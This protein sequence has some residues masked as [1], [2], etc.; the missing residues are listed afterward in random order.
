MA[1]QPLN[2]LAFDLGAES[3]RAILGTLDGQRLLLRELH[4][5]ANEPVT[6]PD[7]LHWD[8]LRLWAELER[9]LGLAARADGGELASVGLDTW[10]VDYALLDSRGSLIG[11]PYHYRDSRTDAMVEEAFRHVPREE[12]FAQ[13][14]IQFMPINTLYQLL[15]LVVHKD[16]Q[17]DIAETLLTIPDYLNY[18]LTGRVVSEF[19]NATTTQCYNPRTR[20]WAWP[21]LEALGIPARLFPE[22]VPP[23]TVLGALRPEV[24]ARVGL[25]GVPVIAPACHDTGSAVAAVPA[26]GRGFAWISCGTWSV[27]GAEASEPL[28]DAR[29]LAF[30]ITNEGGVAD[31]FRVSKNIMGLWLVQECRRT[32]AGQGEELSYTE[33]TEMAAQAPPLR[34]VV[35]PDYDEFLKPGDMPSRIRAYCRATEQPVPEGVG[36]TVRCVLEG[37]ALKYRW[38]LERLEEMLD[39]RLD[40]LHIVGGGTQN[41]LL[42]QFAADATGRRVLAGPVEAT[43]TGNLLM[44]ALALGEIGS[45]Q[46]LRAVVRNSFGLRAYEPHTTPAWEGAYARMAELVEASS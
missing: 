16:P 11:N 31:T 39:T 29:S 42:C 21:L 36:A 4:R 1:S 20:D 33:L 18:L 38:V 22:V 40:P 8:V 2:L 45:L 15:S 46:E 27:M 13:T 7:G 19:S 34:A 37:L 12:I 6:L 10:G 3:G 17:L 43:A 25:A 41:E 32:W 30:N 35:D 24:A 5:F 14:G 26:E 44:Q 23:G 28:I 9:G